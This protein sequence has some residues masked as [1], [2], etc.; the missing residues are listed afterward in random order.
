LNYDFHYSDFSHK[1]SFLNYK[2]SNKKKNFF[3]HF[4]KISQITYI[5]G[6]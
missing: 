6:K 4:K 2:N 1:F 5:K 3:F